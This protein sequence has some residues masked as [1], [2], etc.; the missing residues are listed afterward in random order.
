MYK[1][2]NTCIVGGFV[3]H[4]LCSSRLGFVALHTL[5]ASYCY[6]GMYVRTYVWNKTVNHVFYFIYSN[7]TGGQQQQQIQ[8]THTSL[9]VC[10]TPWQCHVRNENNNIIKMKEI[11]AISNR[12]F[13]LTQNSYPV[14]YQS[15]HCDNKSS[16][17]YINLP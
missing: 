8:D 4:V 16:E 6:V 15:L 2:G 17:I 7:T 12:L 14:N 13:L 1:L 9:H 11:L 3:A 5:H 10:I